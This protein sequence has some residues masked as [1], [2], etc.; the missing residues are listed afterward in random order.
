MG[1]VGTLRP[2]GNDSGSGV[3]NPAQDAILPHLLRS[4]VFGAKPYPDYA[5]RNA[6]QD[7]ESLQ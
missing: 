1:Q 2:I 4:N 7:R 5:R 3:A 6:P